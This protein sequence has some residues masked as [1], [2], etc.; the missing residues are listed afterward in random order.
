MAYIYCRE[1]GAGQDIP[2]FREC[3][4]GIS[5]CPSCGYENRISDDERVDA[6]VQLEERLTAVEKV[7]ADMGK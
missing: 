3:V 7:L 1:C 4:R 5:E 6:L 2:T